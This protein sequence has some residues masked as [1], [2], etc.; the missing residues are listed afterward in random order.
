MKILVSLFIGLIILNSRASGNVE[1]L[2][3]SLGD[4]YK[5]PGIGVAYIKNERLG[6]LET[7]GI[8][9]IE[10]RERLS[11]RDRFHLGSQTKAMTA[12]LIAKLVDQGRISYDSKISEFLPEISFHQDNKKTTIEMLLLHRSGFGGSI[13]G[14]ERI[15]E[16]LNRAST[17]V[18]ARGIAVRQILSGRPHF[19]PGTRDLYSNVSYLILGHIIEKI[20]GRSYEEV[21]YRELFVPLNI[22]T[23]SFQGDERDPT[24]HIIERGILTAFSGDN[25]AIWAPAGN[26]RCS[27]EDWSKFVQ[28]QMNLMQM[29]S[30]FL[31][32]KTAALLYSPAKSGMGYTLGA[33]YSDTRSWFKED[34]FTHT[35][36]NLVNYS[37][38]WIFPKSNRAVLLTTNRGGD[39]SFSGSDKVLKEANDALSTLA[40]FVYRYE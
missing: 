7:V 13:P 32:K 18:K 35:G 17:I 26:V 10:S 27:L 39:E 20:Y 25:L 4:K 14:F 1:S 19:T 9:S 15:K 5:L 36:T 28:L 33:M 22:R 38:V 30:S 23:C 40:E 16:E 21:I 11:S 6:L 8:K 34:A 2:M 12:M 31:S 37:R 3:E 29:R 24:G